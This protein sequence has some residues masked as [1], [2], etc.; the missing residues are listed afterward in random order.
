MYNYTY[1]LNVSMLY[2]CFAKSNHLNILIKFILFRKFDYFLS[3]FL[4]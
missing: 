2:A 4:T 1:F 3:F